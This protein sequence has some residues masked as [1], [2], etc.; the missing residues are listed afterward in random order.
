MDISR[1][2]ATTNTNPHLTS[3]SIIRKGRDHMYLDP[4]FGG[5][6]VQVTIAIIAVGGGILYSFRRKIRDFFSKEKR[7]NGEMRPVAKL[8]PHL[9]SESDDEAIDTLAEE[10]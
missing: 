5:M 10:E 1:F 2:M 7:D 4:G 8:P 6:L 3:I 9:P